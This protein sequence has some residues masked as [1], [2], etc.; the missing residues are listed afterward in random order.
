MAAARGE[1][2]AGQGRAGTRRSCKIREALTVRASTG[3]SKAWPVA[4]ARAAVWC[5]AVAAAGCTPKGT[6][7]AEP[8]RRT[9]TPALAFESLIPRPA[10]ATSTGAHFDLQ[11][12]SSIYADPANGVAAVGELLAERL[13]RATGYAVPVLQAAGTVPPGH[14]HLTTSGADPSLGEEGYTLTVTADGVRLAASRPAG[15]FRGT[16]TIRQLLPPAVE[17]PAAAAAPAWRMA[18]GTITDRPRFVW[19]GAMLDVARHFFSVV[20]V[21][22]FIDVIAYY[23]MNRLHLHLSDDQGWRIVVDKW[24]NLTTVGGSLQSDGDG[25]P[26]AYYYSKADYTEIVAYAAARHIIVIPEI[27]MPGHTNA[28]L[29]SYAEL[30]CDGVARPLYTG[31]EVGFSTLCLR[32]PLTLSFVEDVI[33]EV[34][35]LTP[36][37][38]FHVGGDEAK[39]TDPVEYVRFIEAVQTIVRAQGKQMLG[40]EEIV[41]ARLHPSTIVQEWHD[42]ISHPIP[43]GTRVLLSPSSRVY[44]DMKYDASTPLGQD[45][46]GRIDVKKAYDWDPATEAPQNV[47]EADIVGVEAPLWTE[48][49][50]TRADLEHMMLPRLAGIAEIAWSPRAGRAWDEYRLRLGTYGPRFDAMGVGYFRAPQVPWM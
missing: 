14:V 4:C 17:A 22:R 47:P 23:K 18:T 25:G 3:R 19:R 11:P 42:D 34:A 30:N 29:A 13:R 48:T 31:R 15:L 38:Y 39:S 28:A 49:L 16:Q 5:V 40:W 2:P 37:P 33:A 8:E 24:P 27:D 35:A 21:K 46:A 12:T 1:L 7:E 20:D 45:W 50:R 10:S 32:K 43:L 41:S 6:P 36:G 44:L 9:M 26:G